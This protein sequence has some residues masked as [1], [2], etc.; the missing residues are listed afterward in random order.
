MMSVKHV[1]AFLS[2]YFCVFSLCRG[3]LV[4]RFNTF[5]PFE[6]MYKLKHL[7]NMLHSLLLSLL[8]LLMP[9]SL[10][11]FSLQGDIKI[12]ATIFTVS[13]LTYLLHGAE[14]FLRS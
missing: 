13:F 3:L 8:L 14:S 12:S 1:L 2:V 7:R 6:V 4:I 11:F 9:I 10:L 5:V